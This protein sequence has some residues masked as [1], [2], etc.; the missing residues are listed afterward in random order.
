MSST[1]EPLEGCLDDVDL[2]VLLFPETPFPVVAEWYNDDTDDT[3]KSRIDKAKLHYLFRKEQRKDQPPPL[4]TTCGVMKS[5]C[6]GRWARELCLLLLGRELL[7]PIFRVISEQPLRPR[8]LL[9]SRV[10]E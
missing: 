6:Y 3:V 1:G 2:C 5:S 4:Q 10:L 9:R 7:G 8:A